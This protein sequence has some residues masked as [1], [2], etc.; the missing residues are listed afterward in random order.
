MPGRMNIS[1][2]AQ[3]WTV[4]NNCSPSPS[5][6]R[7]MVWPARRKTACGFL[8]HAHARGR[9]GGDDIAGLQTHKPAQV[10]DDMPDA[11][12]HCSGIAV[13]V[14]LAINLQP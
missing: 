4:F 1:Q 11:E 6:P 8:P 14:A 3:A 2:P 5:T 9:S 13:L 7:R 10:T 12:N